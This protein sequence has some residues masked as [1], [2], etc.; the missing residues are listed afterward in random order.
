MPDGTKKATEKKK[1]R[2]TRIASEKGAR[3]RS[4]GS[5]GTID[6]NGVRAKEKKWNTHHKNIQYVLR[7]CYYNIYGTKLENIT[8]TYHKMWAGVEPSIL[9]LSLFSHIQYFPVRLRRRRR[10]RHR[11]RRLLPNLIN[12]PWLCVRTECNY[13]SVFN[14]VCAARPLAL[15]PFGIQWYLMAGGMCGNSFWVRLCVVMELCISYI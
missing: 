11:R 6:G 4:T 14:D 9:R 10:H 5:G 7:W 2:W 13:L 15:H 3:A 1:K 12:L 8:F